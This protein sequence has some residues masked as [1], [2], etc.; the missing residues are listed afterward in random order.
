[1]ELALEHLL[2]R[3]RKQREEWLE[4][5]K[6]NLA[7]LHDL[8]GDWSALAPWVDEG[9]QLLLQELHATLAP[10]LRVPLEP[11]TSARLLRRTLRELISSLERFNRRWLAWVAELDLSWLNE[12]RE[13]YNR[14]YLLE[15]EAALRNSNLARR[16][17]RPLPALTA[18][19]LLSL[20]P[21]L[22]VPRPE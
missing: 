16:D 11:T 15:K 19:E 17:Y 18:E 3:G 6:L 20:L 13:G 7:R 2:E 1:V 10:T 8:A 14:F 5:V 9:Q 4:M 12:L 21:V 22:F